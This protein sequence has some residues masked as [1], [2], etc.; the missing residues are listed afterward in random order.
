M[1]KPFNL[2]LRDKIA[3]KGKTQ[4]EFA[5]EL[6]I[7]ESSISNYILGKRIPNTRILLKVVLA[8]HEQG[9]QQELVKLLFDALRSIENSNVP[10][11]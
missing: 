6:E 9:N 7:D 10:H 1:K 4:R 5:K 11:V 3:D 2:W 8:L